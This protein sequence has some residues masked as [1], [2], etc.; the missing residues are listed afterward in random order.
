MHFERI[1]ENFYDKIIVKLGSLFDVL[2]KKKKRKKQ[3]RAATPPASELIEETMTINDY[4]IASN[5]A[6]PLRER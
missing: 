5:T 4:D 1:F 2:I 6:L 3:K